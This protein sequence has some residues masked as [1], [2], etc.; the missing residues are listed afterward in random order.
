MKYSN[1]TLVYNGK[2]WLNDE[3]AATAEDV[4]N[5]VIDNCYIQNV[6]CCGWLSADLVDVKA[7]KPEEDRD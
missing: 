6:S 1:I 3:D 4:R 7:E 5:M 2:I